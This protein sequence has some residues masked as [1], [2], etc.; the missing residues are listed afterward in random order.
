[1]NQDKKDLKS[2]EIKASGIF[3]ALQ[4]RII[5]SIGS[6]EQTPINS[7]RRGYTNELKSAHAKFHIQLD[8]ADATPPQ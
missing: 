5:E 4:R 3:H 2:I 7:P 6:F 1:M 8:S